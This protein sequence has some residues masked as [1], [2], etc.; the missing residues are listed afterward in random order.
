MPGK[1]ACEAKRRPQ[2]FTNWLRKE[3]YLPATSKSLIP[4]LV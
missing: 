1:P 2:S 3:S 4:V